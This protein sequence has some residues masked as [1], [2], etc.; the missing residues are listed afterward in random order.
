MQVDVFEGGC[1]R[2]DFQDIGPSRR[3]CSHEGRRI[4]LDSGSLR[5]SAAPSIDALLSKRLAVSRNAPGSPRHARRAAGCQTLPEN[6]G[7]IER[8]KPGMKNRNPIRQP[9]RFIE[10]VGRHEDGAASASALGQHPADAARHLGIESRGG[11]VEQQHS[12][13][14]QQRARERHLLAEPFDSSAARDDAYD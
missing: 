1:L 10:I 8:E 14:V 13:L 12:R 3:E 2:P 5:A 11:L 4:P 6:R 7:P 9:L